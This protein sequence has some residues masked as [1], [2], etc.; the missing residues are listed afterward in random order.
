MLTN[1]WQSKYN[2]AMLQLNTISREFENDKKKIK[3]YGKDAKTWLK[4]LPFSNHRWISRNR[5]NLMFDIESHC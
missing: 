1:E 4:N 5:A 2:V 3:V